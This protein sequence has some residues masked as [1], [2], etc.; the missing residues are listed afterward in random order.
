MLNQNE[1]RKEILQTRHYKY[2]EQLQIMTKETPLYAL[3]FNLFERKR[4]KNE[5]N[6]F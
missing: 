4:K 6:I 1:N 5:I 3:I 2:V